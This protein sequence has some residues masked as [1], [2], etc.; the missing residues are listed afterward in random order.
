[1]ISNIVPWWTHIKDGEFPPHFKNPKAMP[2]FQEREIIGCLAA[3]KIKTVYRLITEIKKNTEI[4]IGSILTIDQHLS[5]GQLADM[6]KMH[7]EHSTVVPKSVAIHLHP[8]HQLSP[9]SENKVQKKDFV[10]L[11]KS[12]K[13]K[14]ILEITQNL[15]KEEI[16]GLFD[17]IEQVCLEKV[18]SDKHT[19]ELFEAIYIKTKPTPQVNRTIESGPVHDWLREKMKNP[20]WASQSWIYAQAK[21]KIKEPE[22]DD[23]IDFIKPLLEDTGFIKRLLE[24]DK[25]INWHRI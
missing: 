6:L 3:G 9:C 2:V 8:R 14:E 25:V 5:G 12:A 21:T 1:M 11:A 17:A 20:T 18:Y 19:I 23:Q 13:K 4:T 10:G 16:N 15:Q 7:P 22:N 24:E